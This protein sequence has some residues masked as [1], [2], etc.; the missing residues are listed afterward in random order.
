MDDYLNFKDNYVHNILPLFDL[1]YFEGLNICDSLPKEC[2][3][4]LAIVNLSELDIYSIDPEGC[5][6]ADDAF[7][8]FKGDDENVYLIMHIANPTH[9]MPL[10]SNEFSFAT[11]MI[12][13]RYP[14]ERPPLSLFPNWLEK[15]CTLQPSKDEDEIRHAISIRYLVDPNT[16]ELTFV[17]IFMSVV[18]PRARHMFTYTNAGKAFNNAAR[19]DRNKSL[20]MSCLGSKA[21]T[22]KEIEN[23]LLLA[24][25]ISEKLRRDGDR[26][27]PSYDHTFVK[28]EGHIVLEKE[29]NNTV[30]MKSMIEQFAIHTN[31]TIS[32][33][34]NAENI[35]TFFRIQPDDKPAKFSITCDKHLD[36]NLE[37]YSQFTSPLRR[38]VDCFLH[39]DIRRYLYQKEYHKYADNGVSEIQLTLLLDRVNEMTKYVKTL[40]DFNKKYKMIQYIYENEC[41]VYGHV[42]R[43]YGKIFLQVTKILNNSGLFSILKNRLSFT[44]DD[45]IYESKIGNYCQQDSSEEAIDDVI[46][47]LNTGKVE[48]FPTIGKNDWND[49]KIWIEEDD[50][51]LPNLHREMLALLTAI[52]RT[53]KRVPRLKVVGY[54]W[55]QDYKQH[56]DGYIEYLYE[57]VYDKD[58]QPVYNWGQ[59]VIKPKM[60]QVPRKEIDINKHTG[61]PEYDLEL[62]AD[63][64]L[65]W[66]D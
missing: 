53:P 55:E 6:D 1:T 51:V 38:V 22:N 48:S 12:T 31:S 47:C 62:D 52:Q 13:T 54:E 28:K 23:T 16:F 7:S 60:I 64:N 25:N 34:L 20:Q 11:R 18:R 21:S 43:N 26:N 45:R 14:E 3:N 56:V 57:Q 42:S 24:Y 40:D 49:F 37:C 9:Y 19:R 50:R 44:D 46:C 32:K 5:T 29:N 66:E 61:K 30:L 8:L 63:G 35:C 4:D 39:Y 36:L 41:I 33:E 58:N 15:L 27:L 2:Y 17:N 65:I 59:P 10:H